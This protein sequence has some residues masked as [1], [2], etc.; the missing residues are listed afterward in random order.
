MLVDWSW[1]KPAPVQFIADILC[2]K[3][4]PERPI[5]GNILHY[6]CIGSGIGATGELGNTGVHSLDLAHGIAVEFTPGASPAVAKSYHYADA[7]GNGPTPY[8]AHFD[9]ATE[10]SFG[11]GRA[12]SAR[13]R[14]SQVRVICN[15]EKECMAKIRIILSGLIT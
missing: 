11:K 13:F 4:R 9:L 1:Q 2:G 12:A 6:N 5:S 15:G 10:E 7:P 14:M 8:W 3:A